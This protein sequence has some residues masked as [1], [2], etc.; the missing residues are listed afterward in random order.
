MTEREVE[1]WPQS[2]PSKGDGGGS[3]SRRVCGRKA[4]GRCRITPI[5]TCHPAPHLDHGS[6]VH[7][8]VLSF[9][10]FTLFLFLGRQLPM[11]SMAFC[12]LSC[13]SQPL[14][15]PCIFLLSMPVALLH[16]CSVCPC[17]CLPVLSLYLFSPTQAVLF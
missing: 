1:S 10:V 3:G 6:P 16:L 12:P 9:F 4:L 7:W 8:S 5:S 11:H 14:H 2:T 17:L 13:S 15:F